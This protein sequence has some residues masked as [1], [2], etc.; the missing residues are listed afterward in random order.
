MN[1]CTTSHEC[2]SS[3]GGLQ[4]VADPEH[5]ILAP[6]HRL[7]YQAARRS[8]TLHVKERR[9]PD[10]PVSHG[11]NEQADLIDQPGSKESAVDSAAALEHER[12][13]AELRADLFERETEIQIAGSGEQVRNAAVAQER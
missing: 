4:A 6:L 5:V 13:H 9:H 2:A 3:V 12:P 1:N 8:V 10:A 7:E 11:R